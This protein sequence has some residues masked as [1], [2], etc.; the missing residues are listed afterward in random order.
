MKLKTTTTTTSP[1][2]KKNFIARSHQTCG[3]LETIEKDIANIV[4]V[5]VVVV[6]MRKTLSFDSDLDLENAIRKQ[7]NK[8]KKETRT[9]KNK[10]EKTISPIPSSQEPRLFS[11]TSE[12]PKTNN[13]V[14]LPPSL[15][16]SLS[17]LSESSD[18]SSSLPLDHFKPSPPP[19]SVSSSS[20]SPPLQLKNKKTK[21]ESLQ[22]ETQRQMAILQ[23]NLQSIDPALHVVCQSTMENFN[24]P[25]RAAS[26]FSSSLEE[27]KKRKMTI[28]KLNLRSIDP[29]LEDVMVC[30]NST[31]ALLVKQTKL[32]QRIK[33]VDE[34]PTQFVMHNSKLQAELRTP[35]RKTFW[36]KGKTKQRTGVPLSQGI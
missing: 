25:R 32:N 1:K 16:G 12:S 17:D 28:L 27:E 35:T 5:V 3:N 23:T 21:K 2:R 26:N 15:A 22:E 29:D 10:S 34:N 36:K 19:R 7:E 30:Q 9:R 31:Q 18:S 24:I 4:I 13:A 6:I 14:D 11:G 20:S 8:M 33:H